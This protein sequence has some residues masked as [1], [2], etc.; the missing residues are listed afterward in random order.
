LAIVG[1]TLA[2]DGTRLAYGLSGPEDGEPVVM[3]QGLGADR[4]GW[5]RQ[6]R[7]F[8]SRYRL[9]LPDNRGVGRSDQPPGPYDLGEM[10]EDVLACMDDAGIESA[11]IVGASMGG[12]IAQIIGVLHPHRTRSLTLACTACQHHAWRRE[13]LEGWAE[14]ALLH[15]MRRFAASKGKWLVGPRSLRRFWPLLGAFGGLAL[16]VQPRSFTAQVRAVLDAD[17][18]LRFE[19]PSI[20][21]PTLVV[22]GSQDILTPL[23]DSEELAAR[24]PDSRL[25]VVRGGA[26]GFMFEN[27]GVFNETVLDFL[28]WADARGDGLAARPDLQVVA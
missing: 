27:A 15:G 17:E 3:I 1:Y 21:V 14:D 7:A 18:D 26:H 28:A 25:A 8:G 5:A 13:L 22:V 2:A 23:G 6:Q 9:L 20:R 19:L 12:V 11:H 16:N 4:R 24:I 10:A